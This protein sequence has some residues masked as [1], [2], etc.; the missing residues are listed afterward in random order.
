ML[1]MTDLFGLLLIALAFGADANAKDC[2]CEQHKAKATGN[3]SC[4][5]AEDASLC[6]IKY[7]AGATK[8]TIDLAS[9]TAATFQSRI[10]VS[11]TFSAYEKF[12]PDRSQFRDLMINLLALSELRRERVDDFVKALGIESSGSAF[13]TK[14]FEIAFDQFSSLQ[15]FD[16][17]ARDVRLMFIAASSP[18]N[19]KCGPDAK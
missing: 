7:S 17:R 5:L 11:E 12:K 16:T 18:A 13:R 14:D 1:R 19:G 10:P 4:S 8:Q 9:A 15:C 2:N 6:S 3:G